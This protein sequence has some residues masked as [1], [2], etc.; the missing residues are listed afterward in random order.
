MII[1]III[2]LI[3]LTISL[4]VCMWR[5]EDNFWESVVSFHPVG[6]RNGT[7]VVRVKASE[8]TTVPRKAT[9]AGC[10]MAPT[11]NSAKAR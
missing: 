5:S 9:T 4:L 10:H 2:C 6:P 7:Q 1:I 3:S 11:P 8:Y